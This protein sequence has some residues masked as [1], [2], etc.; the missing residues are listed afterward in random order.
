MESVKLSLLVFA[1]L[2]VV[3]SVYWSIFVLFPLDPQIERL[4]VALNGIYL[5][6]DILVL[7]SAAGLGVHLWHRHK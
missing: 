4:G 5:V 7:A 2:G 1:S 6:G 3:S